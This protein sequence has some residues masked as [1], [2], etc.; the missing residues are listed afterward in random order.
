VPFVMSW[1]AEFSPSV[2]HEPVIS[3]DILPTI[4]A[5]LDIELPGEKIYDG[6]NMI[7]AI[8]GELKEPL[9]D[10]LYF[11]GNDNTWA[12]R[13][14][15]WKLLYSKKGN[16][17]LFNL[18]TDFIEQNNLVQEHPGKVA[19]L[20]MKYSKWR[21]EMGTPMSSNQKKSGKKK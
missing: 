12:V 13:E 19:D 18:D 21:S 14:G 20:K 16:L 1:P 3:L 9:H 6:K 17:G 10:Q 7:P 15:K 4:C 5:A 11:D 8:Q 2:C